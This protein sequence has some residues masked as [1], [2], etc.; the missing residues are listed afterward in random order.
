MAEYCHCDITSV[1][2]RGPVRDG[3]H[4]PEDVDDDHPDVNDDSP[5]DLQS[6]HTTHIAGMIYARELVEN[7]DAVVG[8]REK[9]REVSEVWHRFLKFA[10]S[11][12]SSAVLKRKRQGPE[13]DVQD[14]QIARWKRLRTVNIEAELKRI[15]GEGAVFRGK[16]R[17]AL[18]AI[19][20]RPWWCT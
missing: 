20:R 16:Q 3:S 1:L 8:R 2:S 14:A 7:R 13:D 17:E 5:H 15:V 10:S 18:I 4:W 12:E 19:I 11:Q 6:G 9:F